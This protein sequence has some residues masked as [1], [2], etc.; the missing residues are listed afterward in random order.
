MAQTNNLQHIGNSLIDQYPDSIHFSDFVI[1]YLTVNSKVDLSSNIDEEDNERLLVN[2]YDD[3]KFSLIAGKNGVAIKSTREDARNATNVGLYVNDN[4]LITGTLYT[5]NLNLLGQTFTDTNTERIIEAMN[6]HLSPLVENGIYEANIRGKRTTISNYYLTHSLT[7]GNKVSSDENRNPLNIN[8]LALNNIDNIQLAIRNEVANANTGDNSELLF[9]IIGDDYQ[10]PGIIYTNKGKNLEFHISTDKKDINY[11][12]NNG[13]DYISSIPKY[14]HYIPTMILDTN[15]CL[16]INSEKSK[17]IGY[18][19]DDYTSNI[20]RTKLNVNG[21]AYIKDIITTDHETGSNAHLNDIY[22]RKHGLTIYPNQIYSG[23]FSGNFS[24]NSNVNIKDLQVNNILTVLEGSKLY[25]TTSINYQSN[26][27][28]FMVYT[29]SYFNEDTVFNESVISH[30]LNVE[31]T[32][33]KD[34]CNLNVT[35]IETVLLN[36]DSNLIKKYIPEDS[37][38]EKSLVISNI[39]NY[40]YEN[41]E[42]NIESFILGLEELSNVYRNDVKENVISLLY[43]SNYVYTSKILNNENDIKNSLYNYLISYGLSNIQNYE[44]KGLKTIDYYTFQNISN[45]ITN[46]KLYDNSYVITYIKENINN[47]SNVLTEKIIKDPIIVRNNIYEEIGNLDS[48]IEKY[49]L[50]YGYSNLESYLSNIG[51]NIN[52]INEIIEINYNLYNKDEIAS[53]IYNQFYNGKIDTSNIYGIKT[54]INELYD[55]NIDIYKVDELNKEINEYI[56]LYGLNIINTYTNS[57]LIGNIISDIKNHYNNIIIP[58]NSIYNLDSLAKDISNY[59]NTNGF[60]DIYEYVKSLNIKRDITDTIVINLLT[61]YTKRG[62]KQT[63]LSYAVHDQINV[64][65]KNIT[66]PGRLGIGIQNDEY[67]SMLSLYRRNNNKKPEIEI[68]DITNNTI[69]KTNI[70]HNRGYLDNNFNT[71]CIGTNDVMDNHNIGFYVGQK[72]SIMYGYSENTP[73]LIITHSEK[74]NNVYKGKIGI[75]TKKPRKELDINGDVIYEGNLYKIDERRERKI[76]N[77]LKNEN[78]I[79]YMDEKRRDVV[80][81]I[82]KLEI[83]G[84]YINTTDGYYVNNQKII[85]LNKKNDG[86]YINNDNLSLGF[87]SEETEIKNVALQVRNAK[88][89]EKENNSVIRIFE[90][91]PDARNYNRYTGIDICRFT[92]EPDRKWYMYN[93]HDGTETFKIG[94][95][96]DENNKFD[97]LKTTH[98]ISTDINTTEINTNIEDKTIINGSLL[99]KGDIDVNGTYKIN[100]IEMTSNHINLSAFT[101]NNVTGSEE[102]N[103]YENDILI[104]GKNVVST[105]DNI[106]SYYVGDKSAY[107]I[108]YMNQHGE[109]QNISGNKTDSKFVIYDENTTLPLL[110]LKSHSLQTNNNGNC[111]MRMGVLPNTINKNIEK[112]WDFNSYFDF[113]MNSEDNNLSIYM[114]LHSE[115]F[116]EK[117]FEIKRQNNSLSYKYGTHNKET[118][119][120]FYHLYDNYNLDILHLE[121]PN[122]INILMETMNSNLWRMKANQNF[123]ISNNNTD[124]F[125]LSD[126]KIGINNNKPEYTLDISN[127]NNGC[128]RLLNQYDKNPITDVLGSINFEFSNLKDIEVSHKLE[129]NNIIIELNQDTYDFTNHKYTGTIEGYLCNF[130]INYSNIEYTEI[131]EILFSSNLQNVKYKDLEFNKWVENTISFENDKYILDSEININIPN[132]IHKYNNIEYTLD[133]TLIESNNKYEFDCN[134]L[135]INYSYKSPFEFELLI[136]GDYESNNELEIYTIDIT[137]YESNINNVESFYTYNNTFARENNTDIKIIQNF[138]FDNNI[139]IILNDVL[140]NGKYIYHKIFKCKIIDGLD[141]EIAYNSNIIEYLNNEYSIENKEYEINNVFEVNI[142]NNTFNIPI[143]TNFYYEN[144][145]NRNDKGIF[146]VYYKLAKPHIVLDNKIEETND[147]TKHHIYSYNGKLEIFVEEPNL[148][149]NEILRIDKYGEVNI[150]TLN[151]NDLKITGDIYDEYEQKLREKIEFDL[152]EIISSNHIYIHSQKNILVNTFNNYEDGNFVINRIKEGNNVLTIYNENNPESYIYIQNLDEDVYKIGSERDIF[153]IKYNNISLLEVK[154]VENDEF[155]YKFNGKF[156]HSVASIDIG[157]IHL[158]N[159]SIINENTETSNIIDFRKNDNVV[160]EIVEN[161]VNVN[162]S[163]Y[164]D[165]LHQIS[166]KRIKKDISK[167]ENALDKI[168]KLEGILYTN[169]INNNRETGLIAQEVEKVLPEAVIEKDNKLHISY[170]N[171]IGIMVEAIKELREEIKI[172]Y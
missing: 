111:K 100:G 23:T 48:N 36:F 135:K 41:G 63:I 144:F 93:V 102:I 155:E 56:R 118:L 80:F 127:I 137:I 25:G 143:N 65:G 15:G 82:K 33:K 24:F 76:V 151:V 58:D 172:M 57:N 40:I 68:N 133:H 69:L 11:S 121:N 29:P 67:N 92:Y 103:L 19:I 43:N 87:N 162:G 122:G 54:H 52:D 13:T 145:D 84:G 129:D 130:V 107:F 159:D 147:K 45:L 117:V 116:D 14:E 86:L 169:T 27:D 72:Q 164:C 46:D 34:G 91:Y 165:T 142:Y 16:S 62:E 2:Q 126:N 35:E 148:N 22:V 157:D 75:N 138:Y 38:Y 105:I 109:L 73:N 53:N 106:G 124:L 78:N 26:N 42:S 97:I 39:Y 28:L 79:I 85:G 32:L 96:E 49:I 30:T 70:G 31:G 140:I 167:I 132:K 158:Y 139:P 128:M 119:S 50:T 141:K 83:D 168:C 55:I 152:N 156:I 59:L 153:K 61:N 108:K 77:L 160:M 120:S 88:Y 89:N 12:Y 161:K 17:E 3:D 44:I 1:E 114:S 10:S 47:L 131:E 154:P 98:S 51:S 20:E 101:N 166:D 95:Q 150:K 6:D 99:V 21:L 123:N 171:M 170:G 134:L 163:L 18:N 110:S 74:V 60:K 115:N 8:R 64:D 113:G 94:F 71:F 4:V 7:L 112:Y 125:T 136:N 81:N 90:A 66:L 146:N 37:I 5:S 104:Q 9:G 149:Y